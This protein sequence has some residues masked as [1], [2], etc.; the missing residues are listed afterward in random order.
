MLTTFQKVLQNA[1]HDNTLLNNYRINQLLQTFKVQHFNPRRVETTVL[2]RRQSQNLSPMFSAGR[3]VS[4]S[5]QTNTIAAL[6]H[7]R[8]KGLSLWSVLVIPVLFRTLTPLL[9][10]YRNSKVLNCHLHTGQLS[11]NL[12]K[13]ETLKS[14][15]E[16]NQLSS[17]GCVKTEINSTLHSGMAFCANKA[18]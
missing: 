15:C 7:I 18:F 4:D 13:P 2:H 11:G 5:C 16:T 1:Y 6:G 17:S 9:R 10:C 14:R 3:T 8:A 12:Y